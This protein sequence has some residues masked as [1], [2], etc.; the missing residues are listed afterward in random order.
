M[1]KEQLETMLEEMGIPYHYMEFDVGTIQPPFMV[2]YY[3]ETSEFYADGICYATVD[4]I[5]IELY[6]DEYDR[7]MEDKIENVLRKYE[8][9][10][11][12]QRE[13][14]EDENLF[15]TIYLMEVLRK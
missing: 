11:Q 14:I 5:V 6:G 10:Y 2:W 13:H 8:I 3:D 15:E 9:G 1:N 7:S 12:K 4:S